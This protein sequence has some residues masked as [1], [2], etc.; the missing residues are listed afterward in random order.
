MLGARSAVLALV[1]SVLCLGVAQAASAPATV[2]ATPTLSLDEAHARAVAQVAVVPRIYDMTDPGVVYGQLA[3]GVS[4]WLASLGGASDSWGNE[5]GGVYGG[6][7]RPDVVPASLQAFLLQFYKDS[8]AVG[9]AF[10][11]EGVAEAR[12]R[13]EDG[14]VAR[15]N[16]LAAGLVAESEAE[17]A[18][19][20][21]ARPTTAPVE[22]TS[23]PTTSPTTVAGGGET[24]E[25][26]PTLN[27]NDNATPPPTTTG[28]TIFV[29]YFGSAG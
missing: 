17:A 18:A 14:R 26:T 4:A 27:G 2:A 11:P 6:A 25:N 21:A 8:P 12:A 9:L 29:I 28:K 10:G 1:L 15:I 5:T 24:A 7:V 16:E 22:P 13:L 3:E 20:A 23:A 19:E